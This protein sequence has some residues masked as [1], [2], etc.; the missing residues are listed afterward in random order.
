MVRFESY[1]DGKFSGGGETDGLQSALAEEPV[2]S[3][4]F[5]NWECEPKGLSGASEI[6]CD[7][8]LSVV[9]GVEAVLL[10]REEV[11]DTSG[12]ELGSSGLVDLG[13][14]LEVVASDLV[15]LDP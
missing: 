8:V 3:E 13:E 9:D 10:D 5:N 4:I 15:L 7:Q 11:H 1:L 2:L 6:S 14:A 12:L